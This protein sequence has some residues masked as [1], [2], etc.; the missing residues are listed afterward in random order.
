[1]VVLVLGSTTAIWAGRRHRIKRK[2]ELEAERAKKDTDKGDE[3]ME[4]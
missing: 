4:I 3:K 1:M 2:K